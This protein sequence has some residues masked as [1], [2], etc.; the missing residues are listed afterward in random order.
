MIWYAILSASSVVVQHGHIASDAT[1]TQ[2][3]LAAIGAVEITQAQATEIK[4][5]P[6]GATLINGVVT[7]LPAPTPTVAQAAQAL[8]AGGLTITSTSAP[9]INGTY[10]CADADQAR[11]S[12]TFNLIQKAGGSSFPNGLASLVWPLRKA[13][14]VTFSSVST[15][16]AV[17][18]AVGNFV[19]ACDQ[20]ELTNGG[21]LPASSVTIP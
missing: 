5:A 6:Y 16:L 10:G 4:A 20:C 7:P 9:A 11:F 1:S 13:P 14:P 19:L 21:T 8:L 3:I 17:E 18:E 12:R 2:A 15:F